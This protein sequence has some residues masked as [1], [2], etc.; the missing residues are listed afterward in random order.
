MS[1]TLSEHVER[2]QNIKNCPSC[3]SP[4]HTVKSVQETIKEEYNIHNPIALAL[5]AKDYAPDGDALKQIFL[6][7]V[8][9]HLSENPETPEENF[10]SCPNCQELWRLDNDRIIIGTEKDFVLLIHSTEL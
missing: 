10:Y 3:G 7:R 8:H 1:K 4:W 6:T 5:Q 2:V 9:F